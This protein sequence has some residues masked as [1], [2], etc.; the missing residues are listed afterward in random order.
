MWTIVG[1]Q[2]HSQEPRR[3]TGNPNKITQERSDNLIAEISSDAKGNSGLLRKLSVTWSLMMTVQQHLYKNSQTKPPYASK[4]TGFD[5]EQGKL[6]D[7][8]YVGVCRRIK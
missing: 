2:E 7:I 6:S 8:G 4:W 5:H 3:K 1:E